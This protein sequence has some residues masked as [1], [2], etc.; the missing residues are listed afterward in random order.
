MGCP[1]TR[2][3]HRDS[4]LRLARVGVENVIG[5]IEGG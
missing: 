1:D 2:A 5:Y 4:Q 3:L